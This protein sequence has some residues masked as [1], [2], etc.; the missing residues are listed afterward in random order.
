MQVIQDESVVK[1]ILWSPQTLIA[2]IPITEGEEM[3]DRV[4]RFAMQVFVPR[5]NIRDR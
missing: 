5:F 2:A 3:L 1:S 4:E